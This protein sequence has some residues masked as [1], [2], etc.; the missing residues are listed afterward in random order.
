MREHVPH[1]EQERE[2]PAQAPAPQRHPAT[3]A[4]DMQRSAGNQATT[5]MVQRFGGVLG[6]GGD[7]AFDYAWRKF[8]E[9]NEESAMFVTLD[10]TWR[11]LALEYSAANEADGQWIK[12]GLRRIPDTWKGSW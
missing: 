1:E 11:Q 3:L 4:L 5:Q 7:L 6:I 2:R 10:P 9:S 12:M 8:V